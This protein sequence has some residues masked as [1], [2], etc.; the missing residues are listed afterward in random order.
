MPLTEGRYAPTVASTRRDAIASRLRWLRG[1]ILG[2][3]LYLSWRRHPE[4]TGAGFGLSREWGWWMLRPS[5]GWH[6]VRWVTPPAH[7]TRAIAAADP[8]G[9]EIWAAKTLGIPV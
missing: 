8:D 3:F 2:Y 5:R 7:A 1:R 9:A 6:S 4:D